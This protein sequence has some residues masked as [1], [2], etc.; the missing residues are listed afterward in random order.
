MSTLTLTGGPFSLP[1]GLLALLGHM[2]H[3]QAVEGSHDLQKVIPTPFL[4]DAFVLDVSQHFGHG[5]GLGTA[6][7]SGPARIENEPRVPQ[8]F[9]PFE[10]RGLVIE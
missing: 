10:Q 3:V 4:G 7:S 6:V 1:G 8:P 9:R 5:D 2:L